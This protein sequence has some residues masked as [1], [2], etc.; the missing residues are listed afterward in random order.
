MAANKRSNSKVPMGNLGRQKAEKELRSWLEQV[1][2]HAFLSF[3]GSM[4]DLE[5]ALGALRL[6]PHFGWK[7]LVL[8]HSKATVAKYER[9][10][11]ISFREEFEPEGPSASRS[12]G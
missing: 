2:R 11:G 9:I 4:D 6:A 1:E 3:K 8:S 5:R 7:P 10:L 12:A